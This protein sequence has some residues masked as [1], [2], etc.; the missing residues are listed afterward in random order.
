MLSYWWFTVVSLADDYKTSELES[1]DQTDAVF[2]GLL[3]TCLQVGPDKC[4][5]ATYGNS[6][7]DLVAVWE[8]SLTDIKFNPIPLINGG[9]AIPV[10]HLIDYDAY[11]YH[12][13]SNLHRPLDYINI[14]HAIDAVIRRDAPAFIG[15]TSGGGPVIP[16]TPSSEDGGPNYPVNDTA[17]L[18][19]ALFAIRCGDK[20]SGAATLQDFF[21]GVGAA[22]KKSKWF[23]GFGLGQNA[24][25]CAQW[26]FMAQDRYAGGFDGIETAVPV[27]LVGNTLDPATSIVSAKNMSAAFEG[28]G[29]LEINGYGVSFY[30]LEGVRPKVTSLFAS[31]LLHL[32]LLILTFLSSPTK[33]TSLVGGSESTCASNA[34]RAYLSNATLPADG[35]ICETN[36]KLAE[37]WG[38]VR[39]LQHT[40]TIHA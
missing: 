1:F 2:L 30:V 31:L 19:R 40:L 5:L 35:S 10:S 20:R 6:I 18:T 8:A 27:L 33:H 17:P 3:G 21:P 26:Q 28:S 37:I 23:S 25:L 22:E 13:Y 15:S 24:L 11:L 9:P 4:P 7:D 16:I 38:T 39:Q 12:I 36:K 34:L 14:S 32:S 29:L